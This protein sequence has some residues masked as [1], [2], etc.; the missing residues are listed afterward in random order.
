M[1]TEEFLAKVEFFQRLDK[2]S[3]S[4]IAAKMRL[5]SFPE[6]PMVNKGDPGDA[7][8]IV[9]TGLARVTTSGGPGQVE[10][11]VL[12]LLKS[13]DSFGEISLIDGMPR[14]ADVSALQPMECY[15][16]SRDDFLAALDE[17]PGVAKG[18]IVCLAAMVRNANKWID[19]LI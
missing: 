10:Q 14:T 13:G 3:L 9:K 6:G 8:Y 18:I 16:L 2:A 7:L 5:V 11:A 12:A 19:N 4:H 1:E 15:M 17:H